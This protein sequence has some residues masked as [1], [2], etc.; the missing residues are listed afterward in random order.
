VEALAGSLGKFYEMSKRM[1]SKRDIPTAVPYPPLSLIQRVGHVG[2]DNPEEAYDQVGRGMRAI[3][4]SMLPAPWTWDGTRVLDFGCG[5]GRVLRH[6]LAE[7]ERAEFWGCDIDLPSIQWLERN[8]CPPLRAFTCNEEPGLPISDGYFSLIY[9]SS[10][11]THLTDHSTSWLL[12]L[13]RTLKSG[14]LLFATFL[15]EG[16]V[17]IIGEAWNEDQIGFNSVLHGNSWDQGGPL[18]F[19]SPWWIRAHWGRAFEIVELRPSTGQSTE[20]GR[21]QGHGLV[22]LRK[23]AVRLTAADVDGLE[24]NEPRELAALQHN[25]K[26]LCKEL[27]TLRKNTITLAEQVAAR[28]TL[29]R[30][31]DAL[32][33][34]RDFLVRARDSLLCER[35]RNAQRAAEYEETIASIHASV[36]WRLSWPIRW[37]HGYARRARR[38][39]WKVRSLAGRL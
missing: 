13:H 1:N 4:E 28:D 12:E 18:S 33:A 31:S 19:M 10:V 9:A 21:A 23:Q 11:F 17:E 5:A 37:L 27:M 38:V 16:M 29:L 30:E 25:R 39:L 35:D 34:E 7:T 2:D 20:G 15:G 3:I 14:G 8:L 22:L 26:Q 36:C 6:F 32:A 24:P